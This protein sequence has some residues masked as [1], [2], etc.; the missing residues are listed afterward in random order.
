MESPSER[1]MPT[2][3]RYDWWS[4]ATMVILTIAVALLVFSVLPQ[5]VSNDLTAELTPDVT[6]VPTLSTEMFREPNRRAVSVADNERSRA[7]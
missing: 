5:M 2:K 6:R 4:V 1:T 3:A 7:P